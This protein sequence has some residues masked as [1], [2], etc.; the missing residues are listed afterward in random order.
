MRSVSNLFS[1]IWST[2]ETAISRRSLHANAPKSE[3]A[4]ADHLH[5]G[6]HIRPGDELHWSA[7]AYNWNKNCADC[8]ST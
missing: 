4:L 2:L 1:N 6:E 8:H 3:V 5:P 7:P